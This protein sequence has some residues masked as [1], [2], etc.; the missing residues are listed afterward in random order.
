M[1]VKSGS[2]EKL[3]KTTFLKG[4]LVRFFIDSC[5]SGDKYYPKCY[6]PGVDSAL[7]RSEFKELRD[8]MYEKR[9]EYTNADPG[10]PPIYEFPGSYND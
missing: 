3:E 6:C 1:G 7:S 4:I 9:R 8:L 2:R 10:F 5:I